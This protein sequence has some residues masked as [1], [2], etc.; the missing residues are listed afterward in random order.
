MANELDEYL[1]SPEAVRQTDF[2][3]GRL[4]KPG[5][6]FDGLRIVAFL[7]RGASS[8][9]WLAY[10]ESLHA[11]CALKMFADSDSPTA[12]ER[13][14][15]EARLLAQFSHPNI[16]HVRRLSETGERPY[17]TMDLLRPLPE[18]PSGNKIAKILGDVLTDLPRFMQ[19]AFCIAT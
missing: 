9:V 17:F 16:V 12:H 7:G 10:D 13:F 2:A 4:L 11:N 1:T 5:D 3:E 19:R 8:E 14:L 15:T 18:K 6:T